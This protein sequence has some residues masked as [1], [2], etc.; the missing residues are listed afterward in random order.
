MTTET[1]GRAMTS[2]EVSAWQADHPD[3]EVTKPSR[4]KIKVLTS[5]KKPRQ[6]WYKFWK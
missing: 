1:D 4:P 3:A 5:N 6:P 2:E